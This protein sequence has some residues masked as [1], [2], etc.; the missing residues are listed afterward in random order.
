VRADRRA[1][2]SFGLQWGGLR[3]RS[4]NT[5]RYDTEVSSRGN[6]LSVYEASHGRPGPLLWRER[7]ASDGSEF[8][9]RSLE[10]LR[11]DVERDVR[12]R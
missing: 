7:G 3:E 11:D 1:A 4:G 12:G 6:M 5:D 10:R 9:S 8:P 2:G